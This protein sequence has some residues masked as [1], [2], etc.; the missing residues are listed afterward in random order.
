MFDDAN[1]LL[2]TYLEYHE[3]TVNNPEFNL[4]WNPYPTAEEINEQCLYRLDFEPY[5]TLQ[6]YLKY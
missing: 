3:K 6:N 5:N 2:E 1:K 4:L